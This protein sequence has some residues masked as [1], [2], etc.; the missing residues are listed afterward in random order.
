MR[1]W[2]RLMLASLA[3]TILAGCGFQL[4]GDVSLPHRSIYFAL[5]ANS[6]L[7]AK[8]KLN[9]RSGKG[10]EI[11]DSEKDAE[12]IFRQLL[13]KREKLILSVNNLGRVREYQLRLTYVFRLVD[14]KG[15]DLLPLNEIVMVRD[16]SYNDTTILSKEQEERMLWD[17]MQQDLV[18]QV[19]RRLQARPKLDS[20]PTNEPIGEQG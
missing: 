8:L 3:V 12:A 11:V 20:E 1:R 4:R 13:E 14:P 2:F 5:P 15:R 10:T 19:L 9:I 17:D 6:V 16:M 18:Q 7:G